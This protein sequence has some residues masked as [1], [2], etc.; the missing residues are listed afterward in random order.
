LVHVLFSKKFA[1]DEKRSEQQVMTLRML[2]VDDHTFLRETLTV[3]LSQ[4]G[5]AITPA[6]SGEEALAIMDGKNL[7]LVLVDYRLPGMNG[8]AFIDIC[9]ERYPHLAGRFILISGAAYI[10]PNHSATNQNEVQI[11]FLQKPFTKLKLM[12][13]IH[14]LDVFSGHE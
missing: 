13:K 11:P 8:E 14:D 10:P 4:D 5:H 2:V 7:D 1:F 12:E 6:S 9:L 3:L